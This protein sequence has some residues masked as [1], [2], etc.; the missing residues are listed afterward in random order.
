MATSLTSVVRP[1]PGRVDDAL[2][3]IVEVAKLLERHGSGDNR[4]LIG[5]IAGEE[6]GAIAFTSEFATGE[7]LGATIDALLADSEY[8]SWLGRAGAESG[9][10]VLLS[11]SIASEIPLG[12]SGSTARGGVVE[13]YVSRM[14]PGRLDGVLELTNTAFDFLENNGATNC[15]LLQLQ[16]AGSLNEALVATWEFE[17]LRAYGRAGDAYMGDPKGQALMELLTSATTPITSISSGV[18]R[19]A[20]I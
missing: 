15:R 19:D 18:Y 9:P 16:N 10:S 6:T 1:K 17:N 8:A 2:G 4:A 14:I 13:V 11:R 12:R 3:M 5:G 7:Q 20:G